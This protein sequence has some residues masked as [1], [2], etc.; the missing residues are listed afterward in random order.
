M[1][2]REKG[3]LFTV[4]Q[5]VFCFSV[6]LYRFTLKNSVLP[7]RLLR[8]FLPAFFD[9]KSKKKLLFDT[10]AL[11]WFQIWD[12]ILFFVKFAKTQNI[13]T[14][15]VFTYTWIHDVH[16]SAAYKTRN[17]M[18]KILN[19]RLFELW[20]RYLIYTIISS[21]YG[22]YKKRMQRLTMNFVYL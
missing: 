20:S 7:Y 19:R 22:C 13:H 15:I 17:I 4:K 5:E 2:W 1:F 11:D 16:T 12:V 9:E 14:S 6:R 21:N 18:L 8:K 10:T 3:F